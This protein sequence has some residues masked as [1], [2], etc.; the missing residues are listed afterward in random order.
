M[1]VSFLRK[2][3]RWLLLP[4]DCALL[5]LAF[6]F[7][8]VLRFDS[9]FPS[10]WSLFPGWKEYSILL[11]LHLFGAI[12]SF[13]VVGIYRNLWAYAS[14]HDIYQIAK[15][16]LF[17]ALLSVATNWLY[18]R[19][20]NFPRS[21]LV[22]QYVLLFL[23]LGFRSFSW[24]MVR[25]LSLFS[26]KKKGKLT[27]LIGTGLE[28]NYL[29][30]EL[31]TKSLRY[32]PRAFID[33]DAKHSKAFIY[34]LPVL[35][36]VEK[37]DEALNNYA[38]EQVILTTK[39]EQAQLRYVYHTCESKGISCKTLPSLT[40]ILER[41]QDTSIGHALREIQLEDL[42]G[43][44]AVYLQSDDVRKALEKQTI[45]ITGAGGSIGRELC[46]QLIASRPAA[47]VLLD[48]AE[49]ALYQIDHELRNSKSRT[50]LPRIASF[51][52]SIC[53]ECVLQKIFYQ[54]DIQ[55]VF[56]CAAYKH[57]PL[58][59]LNPEQ[60]IHNNVVGT[61]RLA[62]AA[63]K[64]GVERFVMLSTDKAVNP[65][66]AMGAS[67]RIAELYVQN[68]AR[69]SDTCFISVRF[70]NVLGSQGSVV[71]LFTKQIEEGGPIT[72]THPE[73]TRY[74]MT[75]PEAV[76]LVVQAGVM[77]R[78][79]EIFIL[80]MGEAVKIEELAEDMIR[81]AGLQPHKDIRIQYTG[82][83]PGEKLF[84]ELLLEEEK[85]ETTHHKKIYVAM[86][87]N[88]SLETLTQQI[89]NLSQILWQSDRNG[90]DMAISSIIPEYRPAHRFPEKSEEKSAV[91]RKK[92]VHKGLE[93]PSKET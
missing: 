21:I 92:L 88:L 36:G 15:A 58:M 40:D 31:K 60:A 32:I 67:K 28:S 43:R 66:N 69:S 57:V 3:R 81:F 62:Q 16:I 49:N 52:G 34:G 48:S 13:S 76:G 91:L 83:R 82:L 23:F 63:N 18:N 22:F 8:W 59:E 71:P 54:N 56:H 93:K 20:E 80:D 17:T 9:F 72:I 64:A 10:Q 39:L 53:D 47:L 38:I 33:P 46:Q 26:A 42:L 25:E 68:L 90:L 79:G 44:D 24:R 55:T 61:V 73:I 12:I 75:I 27:L 2:N 65:A 7:A 1:L 29:M 50:P 30:H 14:L 51:V 5:S 87:R 4:L 11:S 41:P 37:L 85:K 19:M 86:G 74:F 6:Y 45:L 89:E 78:G 77:G 84:E 35:E 70:G